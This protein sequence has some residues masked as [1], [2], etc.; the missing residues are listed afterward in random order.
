MR[1]RKHASGGAS[2]EFIPMPE[3]RLNCRDEGAI[4][5]LV[6]RIL[7]ATLPITHVESALKRPRD[8]GRPDETTVG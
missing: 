5:R 7:S 1:R 8:G 4:R 6:D 2:V 3:T